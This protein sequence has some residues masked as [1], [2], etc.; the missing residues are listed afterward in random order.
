MRLTRMLTFIW[1]IGCGIVIIIIAK[2]LPPRPEPPCL[3]CGFAHLFGI[4]S[5]LIGLG[6]LIAPAVAGR[7]RHTPSR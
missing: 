3:A 4:A 7:I 5:I 2:D 6:G 1:I